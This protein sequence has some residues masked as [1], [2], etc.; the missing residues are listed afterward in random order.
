[1]ENILVENRKNAR[2][3][4]LDQQEKA[5]TLPQQLLKTKNQGA[6]VSSTTE[7]SA[8]NGHERAILMVPKV[9]SEGDD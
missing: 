5:E 7:K 6:K 2:H 4:P 3:V 9:K 8:D 1:M